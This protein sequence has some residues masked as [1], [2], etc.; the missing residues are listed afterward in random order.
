[1]FKQAFSV[2]VEDG[3]SLA[4]RDFFGK[5]IKQTDQVER[6]TKI[7][8]ELLDQNGNKGTF[9]ILGQVARDFPD[10]VKDINDRGHEIGVHGFNHLKFEAMNPKLAMEELSSAKKL[11]EDLTGAEVIGH[12]APA[13]SINPKTAWGLNTIAECGFHYDSSIMPVKSL[14]YGWDGFSKD[15]IQIETTSGHDLIE[16]PLSTSYLFGRSIPF[17]GGSYLRLLPM[18]YLKSAFERESK[19]RPGILYIHPYE[20]DTERYPRYY[21][22]EL[23]QVRLLTNLKLRINWVNRRIM[24]QKLDELLRYFDFV[25]MNTIVSEYQRSNK[26]K[27]FGI[28]ELVN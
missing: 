25:P 13:F 2:D 26:K 20:L 24:A 14:N 10:L 4:M 15:M 6:C 9:F 17:S 22:D 16:V 7:I 5:E 11:L 28:E 3:I 21:F 18:S 27:T 23:K 8:L 1:M 12:R 19:V